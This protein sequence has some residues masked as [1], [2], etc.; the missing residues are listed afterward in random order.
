METMKGL[1]VLGII[2][3]AASSGCTK[4]SPPATAEKAAPA[5]AA[6][7]SDPLEAKANG[8]VDKLSSGDFAG[9]TA[10]FDSKMKSAL[11]ASAL[12][13]TWQG[14]TNQVGAFQSKGAVR[15]TTEAGYDVVYVPC[16]FAQRTLTAKVVFDSSGNVA[17]LFFK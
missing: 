13:Q 8:L 16:Q 1:C 2:V 7:A 4:A 12:Q 15:K 6:P 5:A 11:P 9:V 17:G 10:M 14:L 3:V